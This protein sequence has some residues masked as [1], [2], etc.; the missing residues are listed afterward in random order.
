MLDKEV[1][2]SKHSWR[3][4]KNETGIRRDGVGLD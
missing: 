1:L 4:L 3:L 2:V